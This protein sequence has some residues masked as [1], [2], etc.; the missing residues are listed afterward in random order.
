LGWCQAIARKGLCVLYAD[1]FRTTED[2][3]CLEACG[4]KK[5]WSKIDA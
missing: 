1:F 2:D 3:R 5:N 4:L